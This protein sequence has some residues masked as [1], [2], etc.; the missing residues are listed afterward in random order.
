M[1]FWRKRNA[2][3]HGIAQSM[4]KCRFE[5]MEER[6]MLDAN[7]LLLGAVYTEEDLGTDGHRDSLEI[8]FDGGAAGAE[9]TRLIIDGDQIGNFGNLPGFSSGDVFFDTVQGGLGADG[10][11]ALG[12]TVISPGGGRVVSTA[13]VDGTSLLTIDLAGFVAGDKLIVSIDVDEA[14]VFDPSETDINVINTGFDPIASGAEFA[15]SLLTAH[16]SSPHYVDNL[17]TATFVDAYDSNFAR[18]A[19]LGLELDLPADNENLNQDRNAGAIVEIVQEPQPITIEGNVFYDR[20]ADARYEPSEFEV[21]IAGVDLELWQRAADGSYQPVILGGTP[22]VATTDASGHYRF[23]GALGLT[24]GVFEIREQQPSGYSSVAAIPGFV[25]STQTGVNITPDILSVIEIPYGGARSFQNDFAETKPASIAGFV[26][27]DRNNDGQNGPGEEGIG[28]VQVELYDDQNNLLSALPTQND[29]SYEFTNL[30]PGVYSVREAQPQLWIDGKETL[31]Q[32]DRLGQGTVSVGVAQQD[33][34]ETMELLAEESA[35]EYN[36]GER[37]G[38]LAGRVYSDRDQ[39]CH[40]D[41]DE[42]GIRDVEIRIRDEQGNEL[43]TFTDANGE[44]RFDDLYRGLYTVIETQPVDY[45]HGSQMVGSGS[46]DASVDNHI[47]DIRLGAG[48]VHLVNYDFCERLGSLSGNVY[49]DRNDNGQWDAAEEPIE[50]VTIDL[51]GSQGQSY[52]TTSTDITLS[53]T[54]AQ[55]VTLSPNPN[56]TVGSMARS[57][58]GK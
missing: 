23:D 45:F 47:A 2:T 39:D 4:R 18:A 30:T 32:L 6:R 12:T 52:Q 3:S 25:D 33:Q 5:L 37:L 42:T 54:S 44:Y 17:A 41:Q 8:T 21:G 29:G 16:V 46:G 19:T 24:P 57:R 20:D 22:L 48:D 38:S 13:V 40:F 26:Y 56:P 9:I 1:S 51:S 31:G 43:T 10:A 11:I 28:Q 53:L 58:W 34:F 49:H 15:G 14:L 36:F 7:P 50:G 27:H 35:V 55:A